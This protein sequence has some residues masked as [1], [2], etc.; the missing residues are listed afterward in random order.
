[1]QK[2]SAITPLL[3]N[4][5]T[6]LMVAFKNKKKLYLLRMIHRSPACV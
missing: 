6:Q 2:Q 5:F 3:K 1:M 4:I